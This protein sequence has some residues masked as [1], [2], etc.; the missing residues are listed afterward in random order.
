MGLHYQRTRAR[1]T[2][3][4]FLDPVNFLADSLNIQRRRRRASAAYLRDGAGRYA[5]VGLVIASLLLVLAAGFFFLR[6]WSVLHAIAPRAKPADLVTLVHAEPDEPGSLAWKIKHDERINILL[7]GYGGPGHDGPYLTDSL[8]L[9][10]M[11]PLTKEA[12]LISL[13]RDLWVKIPALPRDG[14][15]WGKL[16]SAYAIGI[17]R[18]NF[19]N[20]RD[21]WKTPTG[22]GDLAV[23]TVAEVTGL[24]I[25]YWVGVDFEAFRDVVN[26][27]G[28]I[29]LDVPEP[30]D[31]PFFP[32]GETTGYMHIRFN[33]GP[34]HLDGERALEY[35]R[36]RETT[37]DFD[38]SRRQQLIMLSVRQR[39]L[40]L[41]AL[42]KLFSLLGALQNNVR[43]SLRPGEMR[44]LAD[45]ASQFKEGDIRRVGIDDKN[46]LRIAFNEGGYVL[47]SRDPSYATLQRYLAQALPDR[48]VLQARVPIRIQDGTARYWLFQ[49]QTPA[50]VFTELLAKLGWQT[51]LGPPATAQRLVQ[52]QILD[53]TGGAAPAT[54]AWLQAFFNATV[55]S[56]SPPEGA[57]PITV[58]LGSDFT[59]R[60]F[61]AR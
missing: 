55:V 50:S 15:M 34:Q 28:G 61:A 2:R 57:P 38:R 27:L 4:T 35:A 32:L 33:A 37:S 16:N 46:F 1:N 48:T 49:P 42:P 24:H 30:L 47:L 26:A 23:A 7:L 43:T 44:Q 20:V 36:S 22:G 56:V 53:G 11:R 31:D 54:V 19:P 17:D 60:A 29:D 18:D 25:D 45:L 41:N 5:R 14:S 13:P 12:I 51:S 52:T 10:S 6:L 3:S 39:V 9:I 21:Q 40:T 58:V 8:L 59:T